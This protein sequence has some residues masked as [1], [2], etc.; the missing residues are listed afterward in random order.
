MKVRT[1]SK[2]VDK[3]WLHAHVDDPYVKRAQREGYRSRAAYKLAEIDAAFALVRPGQRV[4]DL[5]AAPGAWSQY[6]RRRM[7]GGTVV[8][9]DLLP[10][11]PIEGVVFIRGD[12]RDEAVVQRLAEALGGEPVDL[13]VSDLA[14][15]LSGVA[16]A[17]AA[18]VADLIER[19][20]DF[21][22]RHLRPAGALVAKA[23]HGSGY[24]QSVELFKRRFRAVDAFKPK[25]S[26]AKSAETF[27]VGRGLRADNRDRAS[28]GDPKST[29]PAGIAPQ[30]PRT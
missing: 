30:Q 9:L 2:K 4:V 23:F 18:R 26:R 29:C 28:S 1:R 24:S 3:A 11:E 16:S 14:P 13:V 8:A 12:F 6:L 10:I 25:S 20:V 21:A 5:G 19:A 27:L 17:D 7:A 15:N 22:S